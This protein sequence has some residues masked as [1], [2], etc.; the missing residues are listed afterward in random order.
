MKTK[1]EERNGI[2][3][4]I[5]FGNIEVAELKVS[6]FQKKGTKTAVLKQT[7]KTTSLYPAKSVSNN[8]QDNIF[9]LEEFGADFVGEPYVSERTNVAFMDVPEASTIETVKAKLALFPK[10]TLYR[11][12]A[13]KPILNSNQEYAI[14]Q[15]LKTMDDFANAQAVKYG[16]D[17]DKGHVKG[18][19]I[20]DKHGKVQ[21]K[22]TYFSTTE[23]ED[24]DLRNDIPDDQYLTPELEL[25][26]N[27]ALLL[28]V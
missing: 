15:G 6:D 3:S 28:A 25:E 24:M 20:L 23:K 12:M 22:V 26:Y 11:I 2:K 5:V 21:Y 27:E 14:K 18:N 16:Q 13:N 17:D 9:G 8:L 19:L 1:I 7:V 4:T 10:A